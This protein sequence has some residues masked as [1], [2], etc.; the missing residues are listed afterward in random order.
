MIVDFTFSCGLIKHRGGGK[1]VVATSYD[2]ATQ[3]RKKYSNAAECIAELGKTKVIVLHDV[4][5]TKLHKI[6]L[7]HNGHAIVPLF[8]YII[9]NFPHSG[10]QRVHINRALLRDFFVS[11]RSKL[12]FSGEVHITLK[13][14][15]PYSN[16]LVEDQ[17][18][19]AG[20]VLK[21]RLRF[22]LQD[23]PGYNHRTTDPQAKV[24]DAELCLTYVFIVNR[25][26]VPYVK[27]SPPAYAITLI[28]IYSTQCPP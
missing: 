14:K 21:D 1:G 8:Q 28:F 25:S 22:R 26:K 15:P 7:N 27:S 11:A 23:F 19:A 9:F 24:F 2:S 17:A 4:D 6:P 12:L 13:N 3:V 10:Q 16:W 5:A 20:F 18:K